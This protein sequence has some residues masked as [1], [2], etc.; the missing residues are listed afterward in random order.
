MEYEITNSGQFYYDYTRNVIELSSSQLSIDKLTDD[1]LIEYLSD[2]LTHEHLH[3][4][5]LSLFAKS[6]GKNVGYIASSL[7]DSI[8]HLFNR[9][10]DLDK[11]SVKGTISE[12]WKEA[13][14]KYG[15]G[16]LFNHYGIS[17]LNYDKILPSLTGDERIKEMI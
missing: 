16:V 14:D 9:R 8:S 2:V 3:K 15:T 1:E 5:I 13:I 6:Y 17:R 12:T 11:K 4:I 7:F 10:N